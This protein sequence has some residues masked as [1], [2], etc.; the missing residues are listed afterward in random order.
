MAYSLKSCVWELTLACCFSCQYC[1]SKGGKARK[2]ELTTEEC[3]EVVKQL[4]ELGCRRVS[5]IGGEVFMR[6]D[7]DVIVE[8][9]INHGIKVCIIFTKLIDKPFPQLTV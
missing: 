3:L 2:D 5:L 6:S 8:A 7:W 4:S 1:G 9:L